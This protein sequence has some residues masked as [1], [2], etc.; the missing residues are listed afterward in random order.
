MRDTQRGNHSARGF[1][2]HKRW[3]ELRYRRKRVYAA[4][5][6]TKYV[7]GVCDDALDHSCNRLD[8]LGSSAYAV[9][10]SKSERRWRLQKYGLTQKHFHRLVQVLLWGFFSVCGVWSRFVVP[11]QVAAQRERPVAAVVGHGAASAGWNS[12][13]SRHGTAPVK[14]FCGFLRRIYILGAHAQWTYAALMMIDEYRTSQ[15]CSRCIQLSLKKF[16]P[17]G[18]HKLL[19]CHSKE[20]KRPA[21]QPLPEGTTRELPLDRDLSAARNI[22]SITVALVFPT[23]DVTRLSRVFRQTR[24]ANRVFPAVGAP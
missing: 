11:A 18:V 12:I 10:T 13:I 23:A 7:C 8:V 17:T 19:A 16:A 2:S 15:V 3:Q 21:D 5:P 22:T 6:K 14:S 4:L 24:P 20:C 1:T 9:M